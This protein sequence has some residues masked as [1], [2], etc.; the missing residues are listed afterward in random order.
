MREIAE[1][2]L[3]GTMCSVCGQYFRH[4]K[5]DPLKNGDTIQVYTHGYPV[6]CRDCWNPGMRKDGIQKARV[7]VI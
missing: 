2:M 6:A 4:P 3:D 1:D 7:S 5:Q